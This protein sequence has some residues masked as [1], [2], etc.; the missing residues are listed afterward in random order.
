MQKFTVVLHDS[1]NEAE[2]E[3]LDDFNYVG[4]RHHY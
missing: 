3:W 4:S 2:A 1:G